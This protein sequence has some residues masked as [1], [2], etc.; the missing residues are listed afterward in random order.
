[1]VDPFLQVIE[2]LQP[3]APYSKQ[4]DAAGAWRVRRSDVGRAFYGLVLSGGSRLELDGRPALDLHA[5]DF[6][7]VPDALSF[8]MSSQ[9]PTAPAELESQPVLVDGEAGHVRVGEADRPVDTQLLIGYCQF[10]ATDSDMLLPLLPDRVVVRGD[11]RLG[12]L[13]QLVRD[14]ARYQRP[15]RERV[16]EHLLQVLL[17]EALRSAPETETSSGLLNGLADERLAQAL[18]SM[19]DAPERNWSVADLAAQAALSRSAFFNRFIERVGM[20]PMSYLKRW[21]MSLAKAYLR[22]GHDSV[23]TIAAKVG[24]GSGSAFSVAFSRYVGCS[25]GHYQASVVNQLSAT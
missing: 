9:K 7:L 1:M 15:A 24:Y 3:R 22:A 17:I 16:L 19:H 18:H 6:V 12:N 23:A 13:A 25:P 10:E 5:G 2:L 14:E 11:S 20:P 21:R 8:A 4:V